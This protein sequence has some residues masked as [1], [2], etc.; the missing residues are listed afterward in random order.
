MGKGCRVKEN[1][2]DILFTSIVDA[3]E[4]FM[5][6][7]ALEAGQLVSPFF[8]QLFEVCLDCLQRG[9]AVDIGLSMTEESQIWTID[10][11]EFC[12]CAR[13]P[14]IWV[15]LHNLAAFGGILAKFELSKSGQ[16]GP[17]DSAVDGP[18][19]EFGKGGAQVF[20][21]F[22]MYLARVDSQDGS[23]SISKHREGEREEIHAK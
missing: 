5:L 23:L 7:V 1:E 11:Q 21:I 20:E 19:S 18:G 22:R 12:H 16:P 8:G 10:Q 9:C 17:R 4:E 6:G 15:I 14:K 2:I 13:S 3:L